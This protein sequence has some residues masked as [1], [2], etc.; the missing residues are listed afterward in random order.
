MS[1]ATQTLLGL[2]QIGLK[3]NKNFFDKLTF[4][5]GID[6]DLCVTNIL[7]NAGDFEVLYPDLDFMM[8]ACEMFSLKWQRTFEKWLEVMSIEYEPLDNYDRKEAWSDSF[9]ESTSHNESLSTSESGS[10]SGHTSTSDSTSNSSSTLNDISAFNASTLQDDTSATLQAATA[11]RSDNVT[12]S[13]NNK[14]FS[15]NEKESDV[16]RSLD[17]HR[18]RVHGNIGVMTTQ[19]IYLE[20][21]ELQKLNLYDEIYVLF[22]RE[23]LIP[24]S[25]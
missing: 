8:D 23:F 21:W 3:R 15:A 22:A 17:E 6:K 12:N 9:S 4:P 24:F 10:M 5:E 1:S 16:K 18:G 20:Q 13:I 7:H 2:Y 11:G 19:S 25:Y 14:H